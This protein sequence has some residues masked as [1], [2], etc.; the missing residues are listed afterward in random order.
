MTFFNGHYKKNEIQWRFLR[1]KKC[2]RWR[3][4]KPSSSGPSLYVLTNNDAFRKHHL[5]W[6]PLMTFKKV[7]Y[8]NNINND[9]CKT[10]HLWTFSREF[11]FIKLI[12][13][14]LYKSVII[15]IFYQWH[16]QKWHLWFM[17]T[18]TL[19]RNAIFE[20]FLLKI[21]FVFCY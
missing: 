10:R 12:I 2:K 19:N 3:F 18:M 6:I 20:H 5:W 21:I 9:P 14:T 4:S 8:L 7:S 11:F 13:L 17:L 16:F 15:N 1:V